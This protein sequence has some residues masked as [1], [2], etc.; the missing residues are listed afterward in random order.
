MPKGV[1][2]I[3]NQFRYIFEVVKEKNTEIRLFSG[4]V[5]RKKG[6]DI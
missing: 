5:V 3:V 6:N 2:L 4:R 1:K